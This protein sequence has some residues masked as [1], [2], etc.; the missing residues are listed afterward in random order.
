MSTAVVSV[1]VLGTPQAAEF[2]DRTIEAVPPRGSDRYWVAETPEHGV[3]AFAQVRLGTRTSFINNIHVLAEFRGQGIGDRLMRLMTAAISSEQV[4]ADV[5]GGST[6]SAG[7]FERAGFRGSDE[8]RWH[9]LAPVKGGPNVYL[10]HDLPQAEVA[11]A[12]FGLSTIRVETQTT[13]HTVGRIGPSLFRLVGT[14]PL[15]DTQLLPILGDIDHQ[16]S[17]LVIVPEKS[18]PLTSR[19]MLVS[20]RLLASRVDLAGKYGAAQRPPQGQPPGEKAVLR[21][22]A[23]YR[24]A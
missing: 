22:E 10:V 21:K 19:P 17:V 4:G 15:E 9:L 3:I 20:R 18:D 8:F 13:I 12:A 1:N 14:E 11:Q 2:V 23:R 7:I 16:R 5:F 6:T 24:M